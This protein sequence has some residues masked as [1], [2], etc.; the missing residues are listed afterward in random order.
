MSGPNT[1]YDPV[2][3]TP[4]AAAEVEAMSAQALAAFAAASNLEELK[5]ARIAHA[6]DRSPWLSPTARSAHC[7]PRHARRPVS[8]SVR[9]GPR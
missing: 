8:G 9:P 2:Q 4:L 7:R 6:G 1:E 5:L 3:V